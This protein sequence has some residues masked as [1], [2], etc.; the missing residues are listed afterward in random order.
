MNEV[1]WPKKGPNSTSSY[2]VHGARLQVNK[3]G[4]GDIFPSWKTIKIINNN[5]H[6]NVNLEF[7]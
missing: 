4:P 7:K 3:Q 5:Y 2:A 6:G 1:I